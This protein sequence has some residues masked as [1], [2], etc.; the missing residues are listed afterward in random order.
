MTITGETQ[1]DVYVARLKAECRSAPTGRHWDDFYRHI[2]RGFPSE[3]LPC[4]PLILAA[5]IA[6]D[7]EKQQ[8]LREHLLW[9]NIH[10]RLDEAFAFLEQVPKDGWNV[11]G[12]ETWSKAFSWEDDR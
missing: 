4:P 12:P 11:G 10:G 5:S 3:T 9:A 1:I 8:R 2:T 6:S 7:A